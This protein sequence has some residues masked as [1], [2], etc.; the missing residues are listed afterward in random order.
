MIGHMIGNIAQALFVSHFTSQGKRK[1]AQCA[2]RR[3]DNTVTCA[4]TYALRGSVFT[5]LLR[6]CLAHRLHEHCIDERAVQECVVAMILLF[7]NLMKELLTSRNCEA[8][9][10]QTLET[11]I[12]AGT[13]S[14]AVLPSLNEATR[15]STQ[16]SYSAHLHAD[17]ALYDYTRTQLLQPPPIIPRCNS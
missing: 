12:R 17:Q 5:Q 9:L 11:S 13:A 15:Y 14:V 7:N 1:G 16:S 3:Q 10:F 2:V 8:V 4:V 6:A